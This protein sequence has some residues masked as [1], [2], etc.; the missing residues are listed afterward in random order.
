LSFNNSKNTEAH[1]REQLVRA[2]LLL[3]GD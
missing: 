2:E 1:V 3:L